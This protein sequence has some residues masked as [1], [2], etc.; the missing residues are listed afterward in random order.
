M[1]GPLA[2]VQSTASDLLI[3]LCAA[4]VFT[5]CD[6]MHSREVSGGVPQQL[7]A[8]GGLF[9]AA[10]EARALSQSAPPAKRPKLSGSRIAS[11]LSPHAVP[12]HSSITTQH[13]ALHQRRRRQPQRP[14]DTSEGTDSTEDEPT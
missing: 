14:P 2:S 3:L 8:A 6:P 9:G 7:W 12:A 1:D 4:D 13:Q 10:A 11:K 5:R